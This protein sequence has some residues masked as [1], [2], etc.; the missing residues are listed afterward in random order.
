[1]LKYLIVYIGLLSVCV[2]IELEVRT[3]TKTTAGEVIQGK[4]SYIKGTEIKHGR[5][6]WYNDEGHLLH[7]MHFINGRKEGR[8]LKYSEEVK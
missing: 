7:Q 1:M 2:G 5:E 3:I 8:E 6:A 4:V